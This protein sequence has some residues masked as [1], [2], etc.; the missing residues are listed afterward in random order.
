MNYSST[1]YEKLE[2]DEQM[3]GNV[4]IDVEDWAVCQAGVVDEFINGKASDKATRTE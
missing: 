3:V 1:E 2:T 4:G